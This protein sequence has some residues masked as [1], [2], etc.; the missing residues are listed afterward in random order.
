M[1]EVGELHV[2]WSHG[3]SVLHDPVFVHIWSIVV[4]GRAG[5]V[6]KVGGKVKKKSVQDA[7]NK[8]LPDS[9]ITVKKIVMWNLKKN[10][11]LLL[12]TNSCEVIGAKSSLVLDMHK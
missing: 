4:A 2:D 10:T 11:W 5:M 6:E 8:G 9:Y 7:Q 12:F 3:A 1:E